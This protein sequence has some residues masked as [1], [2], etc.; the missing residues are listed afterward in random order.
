LPQF[1]KTNE[2]SELKKIIREELL[3]EDEEIVVIK[4]LNK[5]EKLFIK[6]FVGDLQALL[7]GDTFLKDSKELE[8]FRKQAR[9]LAKIFK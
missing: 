9:A 8:Y 3:K 6:M 1:L 2:K 7:N 5:G 4:S